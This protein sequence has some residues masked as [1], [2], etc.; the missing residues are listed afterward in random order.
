MLTKKLVVPT[1]RVDI[2][3]PLL[4]FINFGMLDGLVPA[5]AHVAANSSL[6]FDDGTADHLCEVKNASASSVV[7]ECKSAH[8]DEFRGSVLAAFRASACSALNNSCGE[9]TANPDCGWCGSTNTCHEGS[10]S[11]AFFP[12]NCSTSSRWQKGGCKCLD[13]ERVAVVDGNGTCAPCGPGTTNLFGDDPAAGV[14]TNCSD[15]QCPAHSNQTEAAGG[16]C[17]CDP[18]YSGT[19]TAVHRSVSPFYFTGGCLHCT[20]NHNV[21]SLACVACEA[22]TSNAA[23]DVIAAGNSSCDRTLCPDNSTGSGVA[24]GCACLEG[25]G[26]NITASDTAPYYSGACLRVELLA[27][28]GTHV[29]NTTA[30]ANDTALVDVTVISSSITFAI[31]IVELATGSAARIEFETDFKSQ[32]ALK[33]NSACACSSYNSDSILVDSITAASVV[34]A[35]SIIVSDG[36]ASS[37]VSAFNALA[38]SADSITVAGVTASVASM[39]APVVA[40]RAVARSVATLASSPVETVA[41]RNRVFVL[42]IAYETIVESGFIRDFQSRLALAL[43]SAISRDRV[44]VISLREGSVVVTFRLNSNGTGD[45]AVAYALLDSRVSTGDSTTPNA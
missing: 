9:C 4:S 16:S 10:E 23:G 42:S 25:F 39:T 36:N 31:D 24:S 8:S 7:C 44:E 35:F 34:V 45:L 18:A 26:G 13:D 41:D 27:A 40:Q 20:Q 17:I 32:M 1:M 21:Q 6:M 2:D 43:G 14:A 22:G 29:T 33:M 12:G 15:A 28:N 30:I 5:C 19:I 11:A 37:G 3:L 38:A